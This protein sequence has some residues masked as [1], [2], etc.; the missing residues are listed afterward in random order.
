MRA[1]AGA[2]IDCRDVFDA[3]YRPALQQA[4]EDRVIAFEETDD[5]ILQ[6][7]IADLVVNHLV[8]YF[9]R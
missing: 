9:G 1:N 2:V 8:C 6:S 5:V 7:G 3:L 4:S